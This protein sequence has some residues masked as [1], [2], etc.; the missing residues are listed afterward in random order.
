[1]LIK[2]I[3]LNTRDTGRSNE[4]VLYYLRHGV[5]A[6]P[7]SLRREESWACVS[8]LC[9]HLAHAPSHIQFPC[10][11]SLLSEKPWVK[12]GLGV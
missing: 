11:E 2:Y 4:T 7:H 6:A 10:S 9:A 3:H 1:M 8:F 12:V 5:G